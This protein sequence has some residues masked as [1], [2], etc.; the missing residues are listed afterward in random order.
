MRSTPDTYVS[1]MKIL[2]ILVVVSSLLYLAVGSC[3][4]S[5]PS[6]VTQTISTPEF[7]ADIAYDPEG[8]KMYVAHWGNDVVD[9]FNRDGTKHGTI[10]LEFNTSGLLTFI[11]IHGGFLYGNMQNKLYVRSANLHTKETSVVFGPFTGFGY[12]NIIVKCILLTSSIMLLFYTTVWP[13]N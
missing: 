12:N 6:D 4:S 7:I 11:D 1:D 10:D 2:L 13:G 5:L 3:V 9:I 8:D